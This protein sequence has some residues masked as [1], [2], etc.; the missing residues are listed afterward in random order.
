MR[1]MLHT[2]KKDARRLWPVALLTWILLAAL[3]DLDR[4]RADRIASPAE[5]WLN[6]LLPL[7]WACLAALA[8][9][10]EPLV[11]DRNFWTTRPHRWTSLLAAKLAF[12]LL[13]I[14]LPGLVA[15]A[16]VLAARG[17][18]PAAFIP[19]L[20]WKQALLFGA[21]TLPAVAMATLVRNFAHFVVAVFA[22]AAGMAILNGGLQRF[23]NYGLQAEELRHGLVRLVLAVSAVLVIA[24]Q[25]TRRRVLGA[26]IVGVAGGMAAALLVAF[27][28]VWAEYSFGTSSAA[29]Q[30]TV[31]A[32]LPAASQTGGPPRSVT[33]PVAIASQPGARF[34]VPL[35]E[36]EI[37]AADGTR[38]SSV[39]PTPNR[40][41][42]RL[43]LIAYA[44]IP[45][46]SST[47]LLVFRF[48]A[49][50]WE[51]VK[52]GRVQIRGSAA[53]DFYRPGETTEVPAL[54]SATVAGVGR[55]NLAIV[56]DRYSEDLLKVL[57]ESP[58]EIPLSFV[59]LR[60]EAGGGPWQGRL[61][62]FGTDAPG[63]RE[64]WLSP[65]QRA[66]TYFRLTD[67]EAKAPAS[68][69]LVPRAQ[70]SNARAAITPEVVTGR[71]LSRFEFHDV[72]LIPR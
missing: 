47:G 70:A 66:Q 15:D 8:V 19:D 32:G 43:P 16:F 62:F 50:Q 22:I 65:L 69:W 6:L 41:Y 10:E 40:P 2:L 35:V 17:F 48:A 51:H 71:A 11:G 44:A 57:C 3:A 27:L 24:I 20:L 64:T 12:V 55:C 72:A 59:V 5:G 18:S 61:D 49:P 1:L 23:P 30:L 58:R 7:A 13:A 56:D 37:T 68:Q 28:P 21:V 38:I 31:R 39:R 14:H 36:V 42:D 33:L 46:E 54:G 26:R 67:R 34:H 9:L 25:Y 63:P 60:S 53:F 52:S 45:P 4:W 29:P